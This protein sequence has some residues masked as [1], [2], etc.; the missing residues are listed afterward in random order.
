[1]LVEIGFPFNIWLTKIQMQYIFFLDVHC[2]SDISKVSVST[3]VGNYQYHEFSPHPLYDL[4]AGSV[5]ANGTPNSLQYSKSEALPCY[6]T[7]H[8]QEQIASF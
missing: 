5:G 1:M 8:R 7:S 3:R 6:N 4:R 2:L